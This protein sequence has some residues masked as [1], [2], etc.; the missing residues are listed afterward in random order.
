M[1][2]SKINLPSSQP[3]A[4]RQFESVLAEL[5]AHVHALEAG[6][7]PLEEALALFENGVRLSRES[8][9]LLDKAEQKIVLLTEQNRSE[10]NSPIL[11]KNIPV[12][13]NHV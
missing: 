13:P 2:E 6:D 7:L 9:H 11:E 3:E 1:S 5:E 10:Q 4:E 12:G 8:Q